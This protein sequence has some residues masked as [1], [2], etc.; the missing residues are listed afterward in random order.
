MALRGNSSIVLRKWLCDGCVTWLLYG[1]GYSEKNI[2]SVCCLFA[3][4]LD[5]NEESTKKSE[6]MTNARDAAMK[7]LPQLT[8]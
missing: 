2:F 5:V 4:L 8:A 6:I 7:V 3:A 1:F